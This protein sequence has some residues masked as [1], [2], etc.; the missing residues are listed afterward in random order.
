MSRSSA[1][2]AKE[3]VS[4]NQ[5]FGAFAVASGVRLLRIEPDAWVTYCL[6]DTNGRASQALRLWRES[7]A[8]V[9]AKDYASAL[10]FVKRVANDS[11]EP[12]HDK[13]TSVCPGLTP[14]L[15]PTPVNF[16]VLWTV[17]MGQFTSARVL[18]CAFL[19]VRR[20]APPPQGA[21]A[22][23]VPPAP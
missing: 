11:R 5:A 8:F 6:D 18:P 13:G 9:K 4:S 19:N 15:T 7:R 22:L 3:L 14:I 16:H 21:D 1:E 20:Q 23:P 12:A 2:V 10:R 17:E